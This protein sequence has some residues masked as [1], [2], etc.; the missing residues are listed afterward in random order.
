MI[1]INVIEHPKKREFIYWFERYLGSIASASGL[2]PL[3][4]CTIVL[5]DMNASLLN[6]E[7]K[8]FDEFS[9][10]SRQAFHV[11]FLCY[12][13]YEL[14][15]L[16][17]QNPPKLEV[18]SQTNESRDKVKLEFEH[19]QINLAQEYY[20]SVSLQS[21]IN[22]FW[23]LSLEIGFSCLSN[24]VVDYDTLRLIY[25]IRRTK[26]GDNPSKDQ[27]EKLFKPLLEN[28]KKHKDKKLYWNGTESNIA[29]ELKRNWKI[30]RGYK[31]TRQNSEWWVM[32]QI[33]DWISDDL[34][35]CVLKD[36]N[37][38]PK[39]VAKWMFED[40]NEIMRY[41]KSKR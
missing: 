30:K 5:P 8:Q 13:Y 10:P 2:S 9:M 16:E 33:L 1:E 15:K 20:Y 27:I 39:A 12:V 21:S 17:S 32:A 23:T 36:E 41:Q 40:F 14:K 31:K 24:N 25:G 35:D 26:A 18:H 11:A 6:C 3:N 4:D 29:E 34:N 7:I 19:V 28:V 37:A 38:K 22:P